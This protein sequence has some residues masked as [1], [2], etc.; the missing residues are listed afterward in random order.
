[1][2]KILGTALLCGASLTIATT[3]Y[4]Q[5]S[6]RWIDPS[7]S[8]MSASSAFTWDGFYAGGNLGYGFG[9]VTTSGP[10]NPQNDLRGF[11]LGGQ[12]GYNFDMGGFVLGA[13]ADAQWSNINYSQRVGG[14]VTDAFNVNYFATVRGRAGLTYNQF[15]PYITGGFAIGQGTGSYSSMGGTFSEAK[16]HTGWTAGAGLEFAATESV[17]VKLEYLY[18]DLGTQSYFAGTG[19]ATN[20]NYRFGA[21]RLGANFK[22]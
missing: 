17:T 11:D 21:I 2:L 6:G 18:T 19:S 22:F 7:S 14:A 9:T 3:A 4:A 12:V 16:T 8:F 15:M 13:E 1:M 20:A 5:D 10:G